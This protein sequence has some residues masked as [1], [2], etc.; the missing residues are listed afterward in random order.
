[1]CHIVEEDLGKVLND[2]YGV[3]APDGAP[4]QEAVE[5]VRDLMRRAGNAP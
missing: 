2:V 3:Q 1:M 4:P 5:R